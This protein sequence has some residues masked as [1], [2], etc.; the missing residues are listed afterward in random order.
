MRF[1]SKWKR[2]SHSISNLYRCGPDATP[3]S[4]AKLRINQLSQM[5]D[6]SMDAMRPIEMYRQ[7]DGV[8]NAR[9]FVLRRRQGRRRQILRDCFEAKVL[10][11]LSSSSVQGHLEDGSMVKGTYDKKQHRV[12]S[13]LFTAAVELLR[14]LTTATAVCTFKKQPIVHTT[15]RG[16]QKWAF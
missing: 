2:R 3:S 4:S 14:E 16:D 12:L 7:T 6:A 1:D 5:E 8:P 15:V 9:R 10:A 13:R 11:K